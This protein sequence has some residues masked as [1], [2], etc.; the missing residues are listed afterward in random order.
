MLRVSESSF[1]ILDANLNQFKTRIYYFVILIRIQ[2]PGPVI[3][4]QL[5]IK[6][7]TLI[8]P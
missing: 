8:L 2:F 5:Y 1:Y 4:I 7:I 6:S 3:L